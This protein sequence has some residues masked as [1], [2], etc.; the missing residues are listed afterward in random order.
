MKNKGILT[1]II[2]II[3]IVGSFI[4]M[5]YKKEKQEN[6]EEIIP[7][8]EISEDQQ[9]KTIVTLYFKDRET[10]ELRQ[11]ERTVDVKILANNPY[12]E[13]INM[14]ISGPQ[15]ENLEK[16]LP[17]GTQVNGIE[18]KGNVAYINLSR[19]FINNQKDGIE[20][21]SM[22]IYSIVNTLTELNEINFVRILIE[23][24]ENLCFKDEGM[25]FKE[26]FERND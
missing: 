11:E 3:I 9:R 14:L 22:T 25:N 23:G 20:N 13:L 26:N 15:D 16:V 12:T 2:I 5:Q 19:E 7:E 18:V 10:G 8:E 24:E 1:I 6:F 17:E 4:F 21:E